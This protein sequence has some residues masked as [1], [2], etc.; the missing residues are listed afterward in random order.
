MRMTPYDCKFSPMAECCSY[1]TMS[2]HV[3]SCWLAANDGSNAIWTFAAPMLAII[4]VSKDLQTGTDLVSS[5]NT[6][7]IQ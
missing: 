2:P 5:L 4:I 1:V 3:H 7:C 6:T